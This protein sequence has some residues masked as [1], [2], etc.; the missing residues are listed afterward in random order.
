[1][2]Y[3][4]CFYAFFIS[5][6]TKFW[7]VWLRDWNMCGGSNEPDYDPGNITELAR[8]GIN[9]RTTQEHIRALY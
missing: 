8:H 5:I 9:Y 4:R 1:M 7:H 2:G 6:L 3:N